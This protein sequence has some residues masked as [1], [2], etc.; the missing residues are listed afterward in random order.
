VCTA[1]SFSSFT[2]AL[3]LHSVWYAT[4]RTCVAGIAV[5]VGFGIIYAFVLLA[6]LLAQA[7]ADSFSKRLLQTAT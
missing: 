2:V 1:V 5:L 3:L 4:L 6:E 7:C